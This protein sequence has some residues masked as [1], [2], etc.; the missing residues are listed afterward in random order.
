MLKL[1]LQNLGHL[2]QRPN[3]LEKTLMP[4]KIEGRRRRGQ[5]RMWWL[6]GI[7]DLMDMSLN[8]LWEIV[9]DR[10]AW[11]AA[12]QGGAK[13]Q[14]WL[15]DWTIAAT[16]RPPRLHAL[17]DSPAFPPVSVSQDPGQQPTLHLVAGSPG[18]PP[19]CDL[20]SVF[21]CRS[22]SWQFWSV[23]TS[24]LFRCPLFW[25][26][27]ISWWIGARALGKECHRDDGIFSVPCILRCRTL[28]S[29]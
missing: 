10:E 24:N 11:C 15:S 1:K 27:L 14:T 13:S 4:E 29:H 25:F 6:D 5:Q 18:P 17:S 23:P 7:N 12:V 16:T 8:K 19:I 26:C 21:P 3:S 20:S 28:M 2:R 9:K 22:R